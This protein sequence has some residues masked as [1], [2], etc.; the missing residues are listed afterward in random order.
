[1]TDK[2]HADTTPFRNHRAFLRNADSGS[3]GLAPAG[4]LPLNARPTGACSRFHP[5]DI[6]LFFLPGVFYFEAGA[7]TAQAL[8]IVCFNP[9]LQPNGFLPEGLNGQIR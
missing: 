2:R 1:M 4:L 9:K 5:F 7:V 6:E 8:N 3:P